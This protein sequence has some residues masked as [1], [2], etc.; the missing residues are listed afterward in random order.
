MLAVAPASGALPMNLLGGFLEGNRAFRCEPELIF[1]LEWVDT[2]V[3]FG[4][5]VGRSFSRLRQGNFVDGAEAKIA[6]LAIDGDTH[7]PALAAV[8]INLEI[9]TAA[10]GVPSR[11]GDVLKCG[12][13]K[14]VQTLR[15]RPGHERGRPNYC[16]W[17]LFLSHFFPHGN[18]CVHGCFRLSSGS[19]ARAVVWKI[20][21]LF[22]CANSR[23]FNVL[24]AENVSEGYVEFCSASSAIG[25][26]GGI[27]TLDTLTRIPVFETGLFNH[28]STSPKQ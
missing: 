25:G 21:R 16:E 28:S 26:E 2:A 14:P 4:A 17:K 24:I 3:G 22:Q 23:N 5:I 19:S 10:I 12:G 20:F 27:R 15:V 13:G 18:R 6:A 11:C 7:G 9:K 8:A 1:M